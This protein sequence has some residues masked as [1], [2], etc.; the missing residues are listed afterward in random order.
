[1]VGVGGPEGLKV[2]TF[3][4]GSSIARWL[5]QVTVY[6]GLKWGAEWDYAD[7]DY[8][9]TPSNPT[10]ISSASGAFKK[11]LWDFLYFKFP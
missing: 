10:S 9:Y 6:G 7:G 5:S 11:A 1:M 8:T 2:N 3:A 4:F